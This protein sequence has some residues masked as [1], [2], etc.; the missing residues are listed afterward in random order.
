MWPYCD[1]LRYEQYKTCYE[2]GPR[3]IVHCDIPYG[4]THTYKFRARQAGTYWYH[5]HHTGQYGEG[6]W[7]IMIIDNTPEV[8]KYYGELVVATNIF[9]H[10]DGNSFTEWYENTA[11]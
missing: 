5:S 8:H 1:V 3:M 2:D 7:G 11:V 10:A 4:Y 9:Y 6:L